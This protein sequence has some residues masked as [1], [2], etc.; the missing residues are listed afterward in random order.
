MAKIRPGEKAALLVIDVQNG[1]V[2][3]AYN[4]NAVVSNI[5]KVIKKARDGTI[6][7]IFVQHTND[8]ELPEDS[9]QWQIVKELDIRKEDYRITKRCNSAFEETGLDTIL[10]NLSITEVIITGTATNW[11][12]RATTFGALTRGYDLTLIS[13][14]HTTENISLSEERTLYAEDIISEF[15]IGIKFVEYP[16]IQTRVVS[17][18]ELVVQ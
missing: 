8:D 2:Q 5:A 18:D 15:N 3:N 12:I 10:E 7:I 13:D 1:V 9:A 16:G 14:A 4:R 17:S 11:C 6:P